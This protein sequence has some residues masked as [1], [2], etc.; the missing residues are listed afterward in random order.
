MS[1]T[2]KYKKLEKIGFLVKFNFLGPS[3]SLTYGKFSNFL[4]KVQCR[5]PGYLLVKFG[6]KLTDSSPYHS[7]HVFLTRFG[8]WE[9]P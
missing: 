2:K 8:S 7:A 6:N 3:C 5:F 1:K 9:G 4:K